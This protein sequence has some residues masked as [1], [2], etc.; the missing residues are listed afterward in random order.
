[1]K[2]NKLSGPMSA[3]AAAGLLVMPSAQAAL[4]GHWAFEEGT[5]I[6]SADSSGLGNTASFAG[7]VTWGSSGPSGNFAVL[8]GASGSVINPGVTL[9]AMS[10]TNNFTW[11][12]WAN[13][14]VDPR[15]AN[16]SNNSQTNSVILGNRRD[17]ANNDLPST[18]NRQFIKFTPTNFEWHQ[19]AN[20][21]DNQAYADL[22][23]GEWTHLAVVK[24]GT[25]IQL[26]QNG[27]AIGGPATLTEDLSTAV[28]MPLFIGGDVGNSSVNEAFNGF[29]DDVR[30]YDNALS[31]GEVQVLAGVPEP[32]SLLLGALGFG[33][34]LRRKR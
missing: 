28:A 23:V 21:N 11:A 12:V 32:S 6:T 27:A 4:I 2:K 26:Y 16:G 30:I 17:G 8:D 10:S 25:S 7:G 33:M 9:P 20:G 5:G 13:T 34:M 3:F 19:N 31:L 29:I 14:A 24:T 1:M 22:V 18:A 15:N